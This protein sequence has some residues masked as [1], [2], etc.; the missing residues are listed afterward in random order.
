MLGVWGFGAVCF[1]LNV[2]GMGVHALLARRCMQAFKIAPNTTLFSM[3]EH[4]EIYPG[5]SS[6]GLGFNHTH[7]TCKRS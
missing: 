4:K 1:G 6:C 7:A 2:N 5:G 3:S